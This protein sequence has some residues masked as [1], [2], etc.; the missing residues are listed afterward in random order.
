ML[1]ELYSMKSAAYL[2]E[3]LLLKNFPQQRKMSPGSL[4]GYKWRKILH[5]T[6][7]CMLLT[8]VGAIIV[9]AY[10][11]HV[12][13]SAQVAKLE[14]EQR[15]AQLQQEIDRLQQLNYYTSTQMI[16]LAKKIHDV[17]ETADG[18]QKKF[19]SLLIP[20]AL[21]VQATHGVPA[22]ATMAMA[23]YESGY[24][25]SQLAVEHNNFFGLKA[26]SEAWEGPRVYTAT[27]DSGQ[28]TM[29]YFRG[30]SDI[31]TAVLGYADFLKESG[32]YA[33]AFHYRDGDKFV[34]AILKAGYCPDSDYH[35]HIAEI[36]SR[37]Q[38]NTL[39]LPEA[40]A[41]HPIGRHTV[42]LAPVIPPWR[43]GWLTAAEVH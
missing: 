20:E 1:P 40:S 5:H 39:D 21:R 3:S 33:S 11:Y 28:R 30:Y 2:S 8:L 31:H 16:G 19:L 38:L 32:R 17:V 7:A 43:K 4:P 15:M 35:R 9:F 23:I 26:L 10:F 13:H 29:A 27:H 25:R 12:F 14:A 37:H 34:Q 42:A 24:G 22:S 18:D 41:S 6:L 36:I